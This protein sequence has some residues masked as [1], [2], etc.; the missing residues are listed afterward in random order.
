V[1]SNEGLTVGSKIHYT[2]NTG[3]RLS[4]TQRRV[5][6]R[7][8][9]WSGTAP[10]CRGKSQQVK[11]YSRCMHSWSIL[12]VVLS[13]WL[14]F[15]F[16]YPVIVPINCGVPPTIQHGRVSI[17]SG[18]TQGSHILYSC[19]SG[20]KLAGPSVR[21]CQRNGQW[22]GRQP[23]C[24]VRVDCKHPGSVQNGDVDVSRGT[25]LGAKVYYTCDRGYKILGSGIR[26]CGANARWSGT[27]PTCQ[28]EIFA[29]VC[30]M[31]LP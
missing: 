11:S 15:C 13:S 2:C 12:D 3:Y 22:Q 18:T 31:K 5:C 7:N 28:S 27:K 6:G 25:A 26:I 8:G 14:I 10:S 21:L 23:T 9:V 24:K 29:F 19:N 30:Q 17:N 20:Y 16:L 4:G 1:Y